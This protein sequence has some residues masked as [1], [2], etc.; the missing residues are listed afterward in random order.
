LILLRVVLGF[1]VFDFTHIHI[2]RNRFF[3]LSLFPFLVFWFTR[4]LAET[5]RTPFDFSEGESELVSGFNT[6][7]R[8]G[9]F[10]FIFIGEY[11]NIIAI[12]LVTSILFFSF[13][14]FFISLSDFFLLFFTF[15][16]SV[17]FIWIRGSFPRLRYDWLIRLVWKGFL[18]FSLGG[19]III[20]MNIIFF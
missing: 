5:N 13:S 16:F 14:F 9:G 10:A 6:E 3:F 20:S 2:N 18:P 8:A 11:L 19:L 17:I 4:S 1:S 15:S 7:Y 12:R